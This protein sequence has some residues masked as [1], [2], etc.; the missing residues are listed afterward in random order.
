M[1]FF[2]I[3]SL[4]SGLDAKKRQNVEKRGRKN[5]HIISMD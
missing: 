1:L 4:Q 5:E 2:S 3:L